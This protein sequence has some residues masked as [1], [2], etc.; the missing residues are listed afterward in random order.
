VSETDVRDEVNRRTHKAEY[1]DR[2]G[3]Q[4]VRREIV[5]RTSAAYRANYERV[6]GH[7]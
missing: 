3:Q 1:T 2:D 5:S 4:M 6:F 7:E